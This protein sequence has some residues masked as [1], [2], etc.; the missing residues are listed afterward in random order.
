MWSELT[1][2]VILSSYF[3]GYMVSQ[4]P[5]GRLAE[6]LGAVRVLA[7]GLG[8]A[9]LLTMLTPICALWSVHALIAI[10][11]MQGVA[12]VSG[13]GESGRGWGCECL[14]ICYA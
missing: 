10:R 12:S 3:G 2:G 8:T 6:R 14:V 9:G 5:S 7:A 1:Q 13:S 11:F 4:I